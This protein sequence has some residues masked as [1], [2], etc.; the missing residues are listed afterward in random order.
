M[1]NSGVSSS[2]LVF[3]TPPF[4]PGQ[5]LSMPELPPTEFLDNL[6]NLVDHF[7]P[8]PLVHGSMP[9]SG[10]VHLPPALCEAEYVFVRQ[11]G[12]QLSLMP[13]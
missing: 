3:G 9:P 8:P 4:L 10:P 12:L 13:L 7:T 1:E 11:D 2:E 5:F 6:H